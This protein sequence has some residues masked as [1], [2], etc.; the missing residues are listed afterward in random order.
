MNTSSG[1]VSLLREGSAVISA[2]KAEDKGYAMAQAKYTIKVVGV[3]KQRIAFTESGSVSRHLSTESYVNQAD[4]GDGS[5]EITYTSSNPSVATVDPTTGRVTLISKGWT[6]IMAT[7]RADKKFA[8]ARVS[9]QLN[10]NG[11]A[12]NKSSSFS[13]SRILG[14][15]IP[16]FSANPAPTEETESTETSDESNNN[17]SSSTSTSNSSSSNESIDESSSENNAQAQ[18]ED[19]VLR[20]QLPNLGGHQTVSYNGKLWIIGGQSNSAIS[21]DIFSSLNGQRDNWKRAAPSQRFT[22]RKDHQVVSFNNR[23]WLV[24]GIDRN[25]KPLNDVWSSGDGMNWQMETGDAG[26]PARFGHTV[27]QFDGR[28]WLIGGANTSTLNDVWW[29]SNGSTWFK[30]NTSELFNPRFNH[31]SVAF[32][33]QLWVIG[34]DQMQSTGGVIKSND[35]WSSTDGITW[36]QVKKSAEF[37]KRG[38]HKITVMNR[39]LWMVGGQTTFGTTQDIWSSNDGRKWFQ[40]TSTAPFGIRTNHTL[41]THNNRLI[42]I[43][44]GGNTTINNESWHSSDGLNWSQ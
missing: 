12:P 21:N 36:R 7:K 13:A 19:N 11:A 16:A 39:A 31:Q 20:K 2:T 15:V 38:E 34:G 8:Q 44:G 28:L 3:Q 4:G 25:N 29:S 35:I 24:G 30:E 37:V 22:P 40:I 33:K 5:G 23:L 14:A 1:A 6:T 43:G 9:Y 17:S 26:F 18:E 10:V 41:N 27:T 32:N 42:L